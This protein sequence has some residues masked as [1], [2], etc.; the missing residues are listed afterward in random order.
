MSRRA[1]G[2]EMELTCVPALGADDTEDEEHGRDQ[3]GDASAQMPPGERH[4]AAWTR[5]EQMLT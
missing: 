4:D 3:A 5:R 1:R 2:S